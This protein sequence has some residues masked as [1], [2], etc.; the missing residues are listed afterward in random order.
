VEFTIPHYR[1]RGR[2]DAR[3]PGPYSRTAVQVVTGR[4]G[5]TG[6]ATGF[7][8]AMSG[9]VTVV[10]SKN[11]GRPWHGGSV[12]GTVHAQ[13]RLQRG[14]K[15]LRLDGNWRCRIDPTSNGG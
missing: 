11:V 8:I 14:S 2:Y 12:S 9:S 15:R 1:G 7:Y 4:N 3:I 5:A 10:Q 13:L 6:V